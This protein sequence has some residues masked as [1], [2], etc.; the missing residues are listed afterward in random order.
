MQ[1]HHIQKSL[2]MDR[3]KDLHGSLAT[4][5]ADDVLADNPKNLRIELMPHQR[6]A[7]AWL[8]WRENQKPS[9]GILG[10]MSLK[11]L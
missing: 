2:T 9:G 1:T 5:P 4:C 3:L 7:L 8:T 10:I 11:Y 6:H